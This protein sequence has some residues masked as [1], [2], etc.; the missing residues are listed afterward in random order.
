[1]L[2]FL[3]RNRN[4]EAGHSGLGWPLHEFVNIPASF[5][6]F[7]LPSLHRPSILK[8]V[9]W[10]KMATAALA[11]TSVFQKI[12]LRKGNRARGSIQIA[13]SVPAVA[14]WVIAA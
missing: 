5:T 11:I 7:V 9:S 10:S 8:L 4:L 13:E 2:I 1:M 6:V 14:S 12:R 3:S